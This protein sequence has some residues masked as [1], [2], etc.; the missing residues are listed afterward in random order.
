M[1]LTLYAFHGNDTIASTTQIQLMDEIT[2][3]AIVGDS[4]VNKFSQPLSH[5]SIDYQEGV[6][7]IWSIEPTSAGTIYTHGDKIDIV[8]NQQTDDTE[9]TL[10]VTA[11]NGCETEPATK[12]ISIVGYATPEWSAPSFSL[13][14][15]PTDGKVN[16][17]M[18]NGLQ[19]R[20]TV[21]VYNL[22]GEL[23]MTRNVGQLRKGETV[24]L[25]LGRLVSG[26]YIVKLSTENGSCSKKVNV[27]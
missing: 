16:M 3:T 11:D 18:G 13:F 2:L 23:M 25:D 5:Y 8:W 19:G 21:E 27:K 4:I 15:N 10:S 6:N 20:A 12:S 7:Y 22:M 14:P 17:V 1:T 26:L 24:S 9:V